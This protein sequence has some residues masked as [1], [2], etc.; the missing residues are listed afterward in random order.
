MGCRGSFEM[1]GKSQPVTQRHI[2]EGLRDVISGC[3][4]SVNV[5]L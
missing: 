2:T 1:P 4:F 3:G 5:Q